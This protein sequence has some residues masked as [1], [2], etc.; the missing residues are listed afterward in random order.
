LSKIPYNP[1]KIN[2]GSSAD[3]DNDHL[4]SPHS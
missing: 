2:P 1:L 3:L 4:A